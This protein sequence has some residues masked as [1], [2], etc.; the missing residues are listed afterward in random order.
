MRKF[1]I[2]FLCISISANTFAVTQPLVPKS[3]GLSST[4]SVQ[5]AKAQSSAGVPAI[6][7]PPQ[8]NAVILAVGDGGGG[9]NGGGGDD[10]G[11]EFSARLSEALRSI[12]L[13]KSILTAKAMSLDLEKDI[14]ATRIVVLDQTLVVKIAGFIQSS[15][16]ANIPQS[17]IIYVNRSRWHGIKNKS[18]KEAIALH[19][20]L[21]L[22]GLEQTGYYPIS[23]NY[24]LKKGGDSIELADALKLNRLQQIST[25]HPTLTRREILKQNFT[26]SQMPIEIDEINQRLNCVIDAGVG[27]TDVDTIHMHTRSIITTPGREGVPA[28]G[29]LLPKIPAV[30][31]IEEKR[32]EFSISSPRIYPN[33][34]VERS[35]LITGAE[36]I[37]QTDGNYT[38]YLRK[39]NGLISIRLHFNT[40]DTPQTIYVNYGYCY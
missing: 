24:L 5:T 7:T 6:I 28:A 31:D 39:N 10:D 37:R 23:S 26:E 11:L 38:L 25:E 12:K 19:E 4:G 2:G 29:P 18:L 27:E 8:D 33:T 9:V 30:A 16:A 1:F 20:Y 35:T 3:K 34:S 32:I 17:K 21:S 36:E 40:L 13:M 14:L 15:V 22:L